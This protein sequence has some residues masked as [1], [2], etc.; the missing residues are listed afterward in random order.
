M[1]RDESALDARRERLA[2]S[3]ADVNG[4]AGIEVDEA[5]P[6]RLFL[7]FVHPLPGQT[8]AR[9]QAAP[10]LTPAD[11]LLTAPAGRGAPRI[12]SVAAAG[13]VLT[14]VCSAQGDL[15]PHVLALRP[16]L[17]GF[18]PIL[19]AVSY[20]WR[21]KCQTGDCAAPPGPSDLPAP[22]P[23]LDHLARDYDSYRRV[24]LDR[25]AV[26]LP[27]WTD[28]NPADLGV[29]LVEMLAAVGDQLSYRLDQISTEYALERAQ[30]R[31][32]AARHARLVG[33]KMSNGVSA[34]VLA[35]V[36]LAPGVAALTLP[37]EG[38]AFLTRAALDLGAVITPEQAA[39][40]EAQ[41]AVAFEPL[42]DTALRA[43]H[44]QIA[45]HHWGDEGAVLRKGAVS[46]D[47]RDPDR[48]LALAAG[49]LLVLV[50][51][52]DPA[53]GRVVDADPA[54]RQA[55]RLLTTPVLL[56]DALE[57]V[58][59]PGSG[60]PE[61]LFVWRCQAHP[62]DA[63]RFDLD[64]GARATGGPMALALGN[65]VLADEGFTLPDRPGL[66]PTGAEPL[67]TAPYRT[68]PELPPAPGQPDE[69]KALA[70][71]DRP[72]PFQPTLARR[73]LA[74]ADRPTALDA[75][76]SATRLLAPEP[77]A[78]KAQIRLTSTLPPAAPIHWTPEPDLLGQPASATVFVPEVEADGTTRLRF[79]RGRDD[80]A[81]TLGREPVA[82]HA[83]TARYRIAAGGAGNI[84]AGALAHLAQS[85]IGVRSAVAGVTNPLPARGGQPRE[86]IAEARQRAPVSFQTQRRAVTLADYE[87]RLAA[88]P[89]VSRATAR[90]RWIGS[91]TAIFLSVDRK[92]GL[93]VDDAFR[94]ALLG[95]IEP[96]RMM[97]H[98][99]TIDAPI[100]VPVTLV[101]D[102]CAAP[103]QFADQVARALTDRL[104][105]GIG[106]DG[107]PG[108]FHPDRVTF[109]E[110]LYLSRIYAAAL[111][112]AG[113]ADVSIT[114]FA[115][116]GGV[117]GLDSGTL[118]FGP[119][120]VPLLANDPNRP[121]DG[122][123]TLHV[124]GGR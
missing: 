123:I 2:V 94:A 35:Q 92:G 29:T 6:A 109:G 107:R 41:G 82:G 20:R 69:P 24:M 111:E 117:S 87:A 12:L 91:W 103:D 78:A 30:L 10:A 11:L 51:N 58:P 88:H 67:G 119:R 65:L 73:N 15:S 124:K 99:V 75:T 68:N 44:D 49:D 116:Q 83:F 66:L 38:T 23:L 114:A 81:S 79:G 40:A 120:E 85:N 47:L 3:S 28:R 96:Y 55:V 86:T 110:T 32:S 121:L 104:G 52:R 56:R 106:A 72:K 26:T 34:R 17:P 43:A 57:P 98:D 45:L 37:A 27:G 89:E 62:A 95:W 84:G 39:R 102:V 64:C 48:A 101:L 14:V 21:L 60:A 70:A 16:D 50:Q 77:T 112:V 25:M 115:R 118:A 97:G 33:Y 100:F 93:P 71:L 9:P 90:Q 108:L 74:F 53:T 7:R 122:Q 13:D 18:D 76:A 63:L 36:Q 19:N 61:A 46:F 59:P 113:V 5:N 105:S 4:I 8:D 42:F 54:R 22:E 80:A 1:A 31:S